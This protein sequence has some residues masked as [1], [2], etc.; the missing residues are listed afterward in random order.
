MQPVT[1][2][3]DKPILDFGQQVSA[4]VISREVLKAAEEGRTS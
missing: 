4:L 2:T 1:V 3:L